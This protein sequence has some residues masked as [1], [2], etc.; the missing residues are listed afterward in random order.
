[1]DSGLTEGAV[2]ARPDSGLQALCA[3]A[4]YYRITSDPVK[5]ARDL[6][7]SGRPFGFDDLVRAAKILGLKAR[8]LRHV[9]A[10]RF[11]RL[12]TPTLVKLKD[13]GFLVFGGLMANGLYRL[14]DPVTRGDKGVPLE[15]LVELVEPIAILVARQVF[16]TGVNPRTFGF[17]WFLPSIMRYRK[18]LG[19]VLL[20]SLFIQIFALVTPLF[21][22]I[23]ID[24]VLTHK[25]Y[26]TLFVL[27]I[28]LVLIGL[29]DVILQYLRTYA[30][31]H[32]TNRIDVELGM[33]LYRH[34]LRL[35][36]SYF[37]TRAAGQTVARVR[38]LETIRAFLTGQGLFRRSISCSPR[39]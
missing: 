34:L 19:Q 20:G 2:A 5:I 24:K 39:C 18:P 23:V 14:F 27:V 7:V 25:G 10:A 6:A 37:E 8:V 29:F 13:G 32:T 12:P 22:Q 4:G 30:L 28:G 21:F 17:Q 15:E 38:E 16:G 11:T 26:S 33:R 36:I 31:S 1:M 9:G 3:V 35:P